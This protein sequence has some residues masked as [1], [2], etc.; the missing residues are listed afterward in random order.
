MKNIRL[1]LFKLKV[2]LYIIAILIFFPIL[3]ILLLLEFSFLHIK[4]KDEI[5]NITDTF[6][7]NKIIEFTNTVRN[8]RDKFKEEKGEL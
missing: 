6:M 4:Y 2:F 5:I 8:Q 1:Y 3:L 7:H